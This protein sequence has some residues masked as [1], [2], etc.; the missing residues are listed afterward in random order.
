MEEIKRYSGAET[1][2]HRVEYDKAGKDQ[3]DVKDESQIMACTTEWI[4][5]YFTKG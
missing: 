1:D 2:K 5:D 3:G 4:T